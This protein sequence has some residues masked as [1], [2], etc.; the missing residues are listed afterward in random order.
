[1]RGTAWF[2][3]VM[4]TGCSMVYTQR[5]S[6]AT[7]N[8]VAYSEDDPRLITAGDSIIYGLSGQVDQLRPTWEPPLLPEEA[9]L[10]LADDRCG[11]GVLEPDE[12]GGCDLDTAYDLPGC[13]DGYCDYAAGEGLLSC[14]ADCSSLAFLSEEDISQR[15]I[16][17]PGDPRNDQ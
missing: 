1:V 4:P 14:S 7:Y 3:R 17:P 2:T 10:P 12:V 15:L 13:G 11:D 9:L 6:V 8:D 16:Y 5:G